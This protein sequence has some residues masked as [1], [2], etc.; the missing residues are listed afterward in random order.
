MYQAPSPWEALRPALFTLAL[1]VICWFA[2]PGLF[3]GAAH[4]A[5]DLPPTS[6]LVP[7]NTAL[8]TLTATT[9][10][11]GSA[12]PTAVP[13]AARAG[14]GPHSPGLLSVGVTVA[15]ASPGHRLGHVDQSL[16]VLVPS[17]AVTTSVLLQVRLPALNAVPE[18]TGN[19]G[20]ANN[21][22]IGMV[23]DLSATTATGQAV[24]H[25]DPRYPLILQL[26]YDP[27]QIVGVDPASLRV[28]YF[29]VSRRDWRPLPTT[30]DTTYHLLTATTTHLTLFAVRVTARTQAQI[31]R[32][33]ARLAALAAAGP[34]QVRSVPITG[35]QDFAGVPLLISVPSGRQQAPVFIQVT[36]VPHAHIRI[37][38]TLAGATT[39]H[40]FDLDSQ[41]YASAAFAPAHPITSAQLLRI[42]V[43]VIQG[44]AQAG[45]TSMV[46]LVPPATAAPS[47]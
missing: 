36:G 46:T 19:V 40:S 10:V 23:F 35:Q 39:I 15:V 13:A 29:D 26:T 22:G 21:A 37:A 18:L 24:R 2:T 17:G 5:A 38:Y 44:H 33:K 9:P 11:M 28:C 20:E 25:F 30:L 43:V 45:T 12:T 4:G 16:R 14:A 42:A 27:S 8:A 6:T 1:A 3:T 31:S 7:T 34:P 41:G 32:A 47:P